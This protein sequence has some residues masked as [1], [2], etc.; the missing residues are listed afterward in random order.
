M[1]ENHKVDLNKINSILKQPTTKHFVDIFRRLQDIARFKVGDF[2]VE[3]RTKHDGT[4]LCTENVENS[5]IP[6]RFMIT[7]RDEETGL[8]FASRINT[9]G[10]LGAAQCLETKIGF[11]YELDPA[12]EDYILLGGKY[13]PVNYLEET[14]KHAAAVKKYNKSI[15]FLPRSAVEFSKFVA[16]NLSVPGTVFW[17]GYIHSHNIADKSFE[18]V[19]V[20]KVKLNPSNWDEQ[21]LIKAGIK[22]LSVL[23]YRDSLGRIFTENALIGWK[24]KEYYLTKPMSYRLHEK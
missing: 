7:Y 9:K 24:S 18:V 16:D 10:K 21:E 20:A 15:V 17:C 4:I 8:T 23:R 13:N 19:E 2:I 3:K 12:Y 14:R 22:E 6:A 11:Y 5:G 1:F